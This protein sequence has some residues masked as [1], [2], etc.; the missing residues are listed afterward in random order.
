MTVKTWAIS[1]CSWRTPIR[2]A[3]HWRAIS[4][5]YAVSEPFGM[6]SWNGFPS[7]YA[8]TNHREDF[9]EACKFYWLAPAE[10]LRVSPAKFVYMRD[11]C[12]DGLISPASAR[13]GLTAIARVLPAISGLSDTDRDWFMPVTVHGDR[14]MGPFDGGFDAVRYRGVRTAHVPVSEQTIYTSVPP[15][16]NGYAPVTVDTQDG[17]SNAAAFTVDRPWYKFW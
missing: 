7:D 3:R 14:L 2:N 1:R 11:H 8:R 6:R 13:V 15:I 16:S 10:L 17:R 5:R 4:T 9:A 12:F